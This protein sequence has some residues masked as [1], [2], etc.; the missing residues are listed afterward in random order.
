[1][2]EEKK[3]DLKLEDLAQVAGGFLE[4]IRPEV[5]KWYYQGGLPEIVGNPDSYP[6]YTAFHCIGVIS[7]TKGT[8]E[9][10]NYIIRPQGNILDYIY[11]TSRYTPGFYEVSAPRL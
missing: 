11:T 6:S 3:A 4:S 8:F 1:M 5:G 9:V 2:S 10:Y 7:D